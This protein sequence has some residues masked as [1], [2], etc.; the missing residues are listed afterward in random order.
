M[1]GTPVGEESS[2]A[3]ARPRLRVKGESRERWLR[4]DG[5]QVTDVERVV[6]GP[7]G[8]VSK[9]QTSDNGF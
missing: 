9:K 2:G 1:S 5:E 8:L 7:V 3:D 4:R 6:G